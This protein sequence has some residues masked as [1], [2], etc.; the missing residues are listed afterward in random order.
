MLEYCVWK[1][2]HTGH[3]ARVFQFKLITLKYWQ[4]SVNHHSNVY[5]SVW[6]LR[7]ALEFTSGRPSYGQTRS[8]EPACTCQSCSMLIAGACGSLPGR[9]GKW[10]WCSCSA[11]W[12][13]EA[14]GLHRPGPQPE[15]RAVPGLAAAPGTAAT[16]GLGS[17]S[18]RTP[19][20]PEAELPQRFLV[21]RALAEILL[22]KGLVVTFIWLK[23]RR[24]LFPCFPPWQALKVRSFVPARVSGGRWVLTPVQGTS[25]RYRS[26]AA[27]GTRGSWGIGGWAAGPASVCSDCSRRAQR[28]PSPSL[29]SGE[30][31][32]EQK[33]T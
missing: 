33:T 10:G 29:G 28:A 3:G 21:T 5:T 8:R 31:S 6:R 30:H 9:P 22:G 7:V 13:T 26:W 20:R 4:I 32:Y 27:V 25:P 11:L 2:S 18:P 16:A 17:R 15:P 14:R 1:F 12:P 24:M 23:M 19:R